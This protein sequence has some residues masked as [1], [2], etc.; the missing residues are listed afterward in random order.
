MKKH[1]FLKD[2]LIFTLYS[3]FLTFII[4][5]LII[6]DESILLNKINVL[7]PVLTFAIFFILQEIFLLLKE[8]RKYKAID[9]SL[10]ILYHPIVFILLATIFFRIWYFS[11]FQTSTYYYDTSTYLT[12]PHNIF[13]GQADIFRT[14]IYPYFIK[15]I[16]LFSENDN[17]L[18]NIAFIQMA[19]STLSLIPFYYLLKN[20]LK[21]KYLI[22]FFSLVYGCSPAVISW[23]TCLITES[24]SLSSMVLFL[25]IVVKFLKKPTYLL[26]VSISLYSFYLVMLKPAFLYI[27]AILIV[28]WIIYFVFSKANRRQCAAGFIALCFSISLTLGYCYINYKSNNYF[29][30]STVGTNVNQLYMVMENKITDNPKYPEISEH[31]NYEMS[32]PDNTNYVI[33]IIELLPSYFDQ[34]DIRNY[35]KGAIKENRGVFVQYTIDKFTELLNVKIPTQYGSYANEDF[36]PIDGALM[37]FLFPF[38]FLSSLVLATAF[39]IY[40]LVILFKKNRVLWFAFGL[41]SLIISHIFVSIYASMAEF[42]RLSIIIAP[43]VYILVFYFIDLIY[44]SINKKT[45]IE[46]I[47]KDSQLINIT[48]SENN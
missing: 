4:T 3:F 1:S 44:V 9:Y 5:K 45:I 2:R 35:V 6:K 16:K 22:I 41:S 37:N 17:L 47:E 28:F 8:S 25:F 32:N 14:P 34:N 27:I 43:A 21:N 7:L 26:A 19:L 20:L 33:D 13:K 15:I 39:L 38:T 23:D 11:N 12:Y 29:G 31:I 48:N 46:Q 24:L 30:I 42:S 36:R 18:S 40:A 10:K